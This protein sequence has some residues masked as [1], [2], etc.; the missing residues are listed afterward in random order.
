MLLQSAKDPFRV[1]PASA[2]FRITRVGDG[3]GNFDE[4]DGHDGPYLVEKVL[5][6]DGS[7]LPGATIAVH[8]ATMRRI[9]LGGTFSP[10]VSVC[11]LG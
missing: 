7:V 6:D 1:D 10:F 9:Y 5:E 11:E 4:G 2:V 8:D 3:L